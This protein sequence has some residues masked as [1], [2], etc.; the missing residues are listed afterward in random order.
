MY[1][2]FFS[3]PNVITLIRVLCA[4]MFLNLTD[5]SII[6][7]V[8]YIGSVT[9]VLDGFIARFFNMETKFGQLLDPFVDKIFWFCF[10]F[11]ALNSNLIT[12]NFFYRLV[13]RDSILF[14]S[15]LYMYYKGNCSF[16]AG[17]SG[18]IS[19]LIVGMTLYLSFEN[20]CPAFLYYVS[21]FAMSVNLFDYSF[22]LKK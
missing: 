20:M 19:A 6:R 12:K 14:I 15:A 21:Y 3:I 4:F 10:A 9:D 18:K 2:R 1:F 17:S 7:M 22:R 8:F 11:Y 5:R 16:K 13:I